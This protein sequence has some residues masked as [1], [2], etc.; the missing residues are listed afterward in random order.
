VVDV[1]QAARHF[2]EPSLEAPDASYSCRTTDW[3]ALYQT[4]MQR[5]GVTLTAAD[6]HDTAHSEGESDWPDGYE[7][8]GDGWYTTDDEGER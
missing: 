1:R 2:H 8:E 5:M 7:S 3:D 6:E 4:E